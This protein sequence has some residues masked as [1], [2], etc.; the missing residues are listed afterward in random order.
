MSCGIYWIRNCKNG[1]FYI[2]SSSNIRQRWREHRSHLIRNIHKNKHLQSAWNKYGSKSFKF[3]ILEELIEAN[4]I[5]IEQWYLDSTRCCLRTHGYNI[6]PDAGRPD[7]KG[8]KHPLFGKHHTQKTKDKMS[9]SR[10]DNGV[11]PY[12][13]KPVEQLTVD[14]DLVMVYP[15][16]QLA[17]KNVGAKS[18]SNITRVASGKRLQAH[19]F[20]WK[21]KIQ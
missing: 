1:K 20:K 18:T 3:E 10:K 6:L 17:A 4:L 11:P 8:E 16:L 12:Q 15:S 21:Y 14:G 13:Y 2:G 9:K 19:G 5:E 7:N